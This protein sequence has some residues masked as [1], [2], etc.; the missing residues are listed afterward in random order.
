[1]YTSQKTDLGKL[2]KYR[3]ELS[4]KYEAALNRHDLTEARRLHELH[5]RVFRAILLHEEFH[6]SAE[7]VVA[8]H[9][10]NR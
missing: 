6:V 10:R 2:R 7:A 1:M 3:S 4:A 8:D 9:L 5:R